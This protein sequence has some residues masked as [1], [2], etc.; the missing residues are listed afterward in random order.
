LGYCIGMDLDPALCYRA[1][2]ARDARY[3]GAFFVCVRT[4]RIYCRPICPAR[5]PLFRNCQFL[6]S[7]AAAQEAG[8]RP[9][10]RCRPESSP[11]IGAWRGASATVSRA[12]ALIEEGALDGADVETFAERLGI[13]ERHLRRLFQRHL[14]AAPISVAQTRRVLL[15]KQLIHETALPMTEV[16]LASG[17]GSLRRFNETFLQ[18]YRRPPGELRRRRTAE[19]PA[20]NGLT[21]LLPYR[22][23]YD[24]SALIQFLAIRAI[25]GLEVVSE[26]RYR[27]VVVFDSAV[28]S[29]DV[30]HA[31]ER[32]ALR[33]L[34]RFPRIDRLPVIIARIR[35]LFD[36]AA[37]PI[38]IGAVLSR[39]PSLAPLVA[40]R[41]GLRAPGGWDPFEI[42]VRA[43]LG[44]QVTVKA[45][46]RLVARFVAAFGAP[47][48]ENALEGLSHGFPEPARFDVARIAA[49][50]MPRARAE[51]VAAIAGAVLADP[52]LLTQRLDLD[53][54]V[55]RLRKTPGVGP[56]TAN[57]IAM[58]AFGE[59]D[60]FL[61]EDV[62]V[63]RA[64]AV[65]GR[66]PRPRDLLARAELWRPWRAYAVHHLWAAETARSSQTEK[67][68]DNA[69][70][71]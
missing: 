10:L 62:A 5:P 50:G 12:L 26:D 55:Q 40:G 66:R 29:V 58:R 14:G 45:G 33:V 8:F 35:R 4:T 19:T 25:P 57:Y 48:G 47:I 70:A 2:L 3:D 42:A 6:P 32:S 51:T 18:L 36:L 20:D 38:A 41:P 23:P 28:G 53:A 22:P 64:L 24:W 9:C 34:V 61:A 43:A 1:M 60:A 17:F 63:R 46:V 13:G 69:L 39:D 11:D 59:S 21:L 37:D 44:Q 54:I 15:A 68:L 30:T 49:L 65:E 27:R 7:A 52:R 67:T 56:W 31:P 16:A 71:A